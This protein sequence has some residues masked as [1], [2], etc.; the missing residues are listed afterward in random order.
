MGIIDDTLLP[1]LNLILRPNRPKPQKNIINLPT[2]NSPSLH[3]SPPITS[4]PLSIPPPLLLKTMPPLPLAG[5]HCAIV[6]ATGIIGSHIA[7]AFAQHGAV[8]SLLGRSALDVRP[9]LERELVPYSSASGSGSVEGPVAHRFIR[10]DVRQRGSIKDVFGA[11]AGAEGVSD[12][13]RGFLF[14]GFVDIGGCSRVLLLDRLISSSI[15]LVSRRL[16]F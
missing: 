5:K 6:G 14:N 15:A 2:S 10:L 7:K 9:R 8:L 11:R 4:S 12:L 3:P 16:R 13:V 1:L